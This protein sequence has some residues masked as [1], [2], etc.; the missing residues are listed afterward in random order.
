MGTHESWRY[1]SLETPGSV[2]L[3]ELFLEKVSKDLK[4]LDWGCGTGRISLELQSKGYHVRGFDINNHNINAAKK[5]ASKS[6]RIYKNMV[7]FDLAN[8]MDL[9]YHDESFDVCL[10][11]AFMTTI[12]NIADRS[13]ILEEANRILKSNGILF[14]AEFGQTWE[15]P[16]YKK[17]YLSDYKLTREMCTFIVT[18]D[19][20]SNTPE[21][22][23][24]HHYSEK[25][26]KSLLEPFFRID[27]IEKRIFTSYHG[28]KVNGFIV[29]ALK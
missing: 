11:Q 29:I 10:M 22:Y 26:I 27:L 4:I 7:K 6:N 9:P 16:I 19:G 2:P 17:R 24:A 25:E 1:F 12:D 14:M 15:N 5:S 3:D 28:N 20:T 13:I 18:K 23:R 21:I 8:A